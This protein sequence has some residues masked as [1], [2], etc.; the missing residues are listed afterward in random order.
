MDLLIGQLLTALAGA[1]SL[2]LVASGL[3]LIF[4]VTRIVNFAHGSLYMLGAYLGVTLVEVL[5]GGWLGFWGGLLA[6]AL[7]VGVVGL[8]LEV[9]LLRRLYGA[10]ELQQLLATYAIVLIVQDVALAIWGPQDLL[11]PRAPGL[12]GAVAVGDQ[13]IPAYDLFLVCLAPVV[14]A[15]LWL[16]LHRTRWGILVRAATQDAEMTGALGIDQ[17]RL[18]ST[19]F[20][21]GAALAGLGGALQLPK[22]AADLH[23]DLQIIATVFV[24]V[25]VGGLGSILGAYLAS[26]LIALLRVAAVANADAALFGVGVWQLELVLVFLVMALVLVVR[27]TGLLGRAEMARSPRALPPAPPLRPAGRRWQAAA[28]AVVA[29]LAFM[30]WLAGP[31]SLSLLSEALVLALF[32]A[33]L[34]FASGVGGMISFGHAAYFG[35]GAYAS[36][37]LVRWL[38]AD[39][40]TALALA[41]VAGLAAGLL[42]GWFCVRLSGVYL[43]MLTLAFA[44]IA[45]SLAFQW[46]TFTGGD[47]GLLGVWPAAW[48]ASP[49]DFYLLTLALVVPALALLRRV[50]FSPFG[51]ALR[52]LRDHPGRAEAS[53]LAVF[54]QRW[55]AFALSGA[56]AGLAGGLH[57]FLKGTVGPDRL[58]IPF[59]VDGLV[60]V[61]LGGL[62]S[63]TGPLVGA[64][65]FTFL[66]AELLSLTDYWRLCLGLIILIVVIG[67]P[68]GLADLPRAVRSGR[69]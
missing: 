29:L 26:L 38:A 30:P 7:V 16:L 64:G 6:A 23:M 21:L 56:F 59:S 54:R 66:R 24:V 34:Q 57:A 61:L 52:A 67:L 37:L 50:T 5:P 65:L 22:G 1:S 47:N 53:G 49:T 62:Y 25:V 13:L 15:A 17:R 44:Q 35:F 8:L 31:Y 58:A 12:R 36:G 51:L 32:A 46:T 68:R 45:W 9:L 27:P 20:F 11:G 19:V 42:F 14:L 69:R 3:S 48:G 43:A 28:A 60:M 18:F 55:L 63:L 39:M 33:S 40:L 4:G 41:P 10:P 2:F